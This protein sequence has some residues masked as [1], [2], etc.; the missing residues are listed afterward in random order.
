MNFMSKYSSILLSVMRIMVGGLFLEHGTGKI[1]S[2]PY[3][4]TF[5]KQV[6][7]QMSGG[8]AGTLEVV[9]GIPIVLGLFSRPAAFIAAGQCAVIYWFFDM[10]RAFFPVISAGDR[11]DVGAAIVFCFVFLYVAAVGPGPI[12]INQK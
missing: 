4:P 8:I 3:Y 10:P 2:F 12:A 7:W 6:F 1:L 9:L 11:S 5:A